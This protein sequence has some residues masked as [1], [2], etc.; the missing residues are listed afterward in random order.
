MRPH[1]ISRASASNRAW[2][3]PILMVNWP[4]SRRLCVGAK[5]TGPM[6]IYAGDQ[7]MRC[8]AVST[9][10]AGWIICLMFTRQDLVRFREQRVPC[11]SS[12]DCGSA[13]TRGSRSA[14]VVGS[15]GDAKVLRAVSPGGICLESIFCPTAN[16]RR[17]ALAKPARLEHLLAEHSCRPRKPRPS[18]ACAP[19]PR[20]S[21]AT[22][23]TDIVA[24]IAY[25]CVDL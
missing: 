18:G 23:P 4:R 6:S 20:L 3:S 19:L 21:H 1:G 15:R 5:C 12:R 14:P 7:H 17:L 22:G 13:G 10:R 25:V 9:C 2:R 24:R 8:G 11:L 16:A